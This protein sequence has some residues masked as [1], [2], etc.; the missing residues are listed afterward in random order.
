MACQITQPI[1]STIESNDHCS[2]R[3]PQNPIS[4]TSSL[5]RTTFFDYRSISITIPISVPIFNRFWVDLGWPLDPKILQN[6]VRGVRNQTLRINT[7]D[8][9]PMSSRTDFRHP[10]LLQS[11]SKIAPRR[12][13]GDPSMV[14]EP[15]FE[16]RS[17][18]P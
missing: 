17:P 12:S 8:V 6:C 10:K 18:Q 1:Y 5:P 11:C 7:L 2:A 14:A 15:I 16:G 13:A 4:D 3:D 9:D